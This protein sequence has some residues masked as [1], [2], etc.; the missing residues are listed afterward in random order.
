MIL[1]RAK[2]ER[3]QLIFLIDFIKKKMKE[4]L[5][6]KSINMPKKELFRIKKNIPQM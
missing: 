1:K 6:K 3:V 2:R 5:R 4:T